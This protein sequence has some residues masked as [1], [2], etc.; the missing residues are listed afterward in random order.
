MKSR[1]SRLSAIVACT[2]TPVNSVSSGV[3]TTSR[4]PSAVVPTITSL[5]RKVSG[6]DPAVEDVGGRDVRERALPTPVPQQQIALAIERDAPAV[7][8][9]RVR[10]GDA[11]SVAA[12]DV[13]DV[14][15]TCRVRSRSARD[16]GET[17]RRIDPSVELHHAAARG[18]AVHPDP[19]PR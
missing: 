11:T 16:G 4:V 13:G 2:S 17:E 6:A 18:E 10:V 19:G 3:E 8:V 5:L 1:W 7:I 15:A 9:R 14:E 12:V